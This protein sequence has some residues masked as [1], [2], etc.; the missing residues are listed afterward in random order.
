M[1]KNAINP[2]YAQFYTYLFRINHLSNKDVFKITSSAAFLYKGSNG[3]ISTL[4]YETFIPVCGR[5]RVEYPNNL[6]DGV[7]E[8]LSIQS[9]ILLTTPSL[10]LEYTVNS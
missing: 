3:S 6:R 8:P 5:R 9:N 10:L 2:A 4:I 7:E 1:S